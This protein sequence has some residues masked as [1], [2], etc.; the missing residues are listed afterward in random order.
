MS[1]GGEE[2]E[3]MKKRKA[4]TQRERAERWAKCNVWVDDERTERITQRG[5]S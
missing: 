2:G 1:E 4:M 3:A 5:A